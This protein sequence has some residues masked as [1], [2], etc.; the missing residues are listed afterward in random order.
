MAIVLGLSFAVMTMIMLSQAERDVTYHT[1]EQLSHTAARSALYTFLNSKRE[2]NKGELNAYNAMSLCWSGRP[3]TVADQVSNM[4]A[5]D[6]GMINYPVPHLTGKARP[7][8]LQWIKVEGARPKILDGCESDDINNT[9]G[10][11]GKRDASQMA[12][13]GVHTYQ[14]KV[15][16]AGGNLETVNMYY[17]AKVG[18]IEN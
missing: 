9:V 8:L 1:T 17:A 14:V 12:D 5:I 13:G 2:T 16:V 10:I 18:V 7:R 4:D 11:R 15:P 3:L 6:R